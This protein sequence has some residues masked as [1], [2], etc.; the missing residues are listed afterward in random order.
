MQSKSYHTPRERVL[1]QLR[2]EADR[3][4]RAVD[5]L[6]R[7]FNNATPLR[8]LEMSG[9]RRHDGRECDDQKRLAELLVSLVFS[10]PV[11]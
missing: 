3:H 6:V 8:Q 5:D 11:V 2:D 1:A 9:F 7:R 10:D 4:L